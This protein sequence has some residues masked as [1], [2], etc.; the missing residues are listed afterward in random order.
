MGFTSETG[1]EAGKLSKRGPA[2]VSKELKAKLEN[3]TLGMLEDIDFRTLS[4]SDKIRLLQI[5]IGYVLPK[6]KAIAINNEADNQPTDFEI[7]IIDENG[8]CNKRLK[9]EPKE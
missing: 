1:A 4:N 8:D 3:L 9:L 2:K 5:T 7:R 6:L